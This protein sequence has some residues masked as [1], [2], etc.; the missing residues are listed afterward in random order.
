[1][2]E[3]NIYDF[4]MVSGAGCI[5]QTFSGAANG[6]T[7]GAAIGGAVGLGIAVATGGG[8]TPLILGFGTIG[9]GIG[10][11]SGAIAVGYECYQE[12]KLKDQSGNDYGDGTGY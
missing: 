4:E 9:G 10:A 5:E 7:A 8:G 1:M 3:L 12:S 6:A 2:I 11:V